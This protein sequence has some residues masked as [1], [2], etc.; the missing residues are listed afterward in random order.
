MNSFFNPIKVVEEKNAN[1]RT[2]SFISLE[3]GAYYSILEKAG[4]KIVLLG[5]CSE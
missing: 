5:E 4:R 1:R 3:L 2:E